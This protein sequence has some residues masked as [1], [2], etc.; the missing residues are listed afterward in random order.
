MIARLI[1]EDIRVFSNLSPAVGSV[2]IDPAHLEQA[3]INLA[4]NSRHAMPTGGALIFETAPVDGGRRVRI[5]VRDSGHGMDEVTQQRAFEPFFTTK[6]S[7]KGSSL[8]LIHC[9]YTQAARDR[10]GFLR[11]L[12]APVTVFRPATFL[13]RTNELPMDCFADDRCRTARHHGRTSFAGAVRR[14]G[15]QRRAG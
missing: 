10:T 12:F 8:Q 4:V 9:S 5:V 6:P 13:V 1:A 2:L 15:Q 11:R 14:A 3:L 7:G